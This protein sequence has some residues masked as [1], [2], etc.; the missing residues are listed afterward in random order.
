VWGLFEM[1]RNVERDLQRENERRKQLL[2]AGFELFSENGIENVSLQAVAERANVGI[3][4]LYNYYQNKIKLV[5]AIS[6]DMWGKV[7]QEYYDN[8]DMNAF[9][10]YS[11]YQRIEAYL[12]IMINLYKEHPEILRFSGDYKTFIQRQK[13]EVS[14]LDEHFGALKPVNNMFHI[15][16]EKAKVDKT[17]RTDIP[18]AELFTIVALTMLGMAERYASGIVWTKNDSNDYIN[19]LICLKEM[20]LNWLKNG[21]P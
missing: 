11:A 17:I 15:S 20:M 4:T 8:T 5:I 21:T 2:K 9:N 12:D 7:W 13:A 10:D 1:A 19:E 16:Y 3:A 14:D 6:A 18:E